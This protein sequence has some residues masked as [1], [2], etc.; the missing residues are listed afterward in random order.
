MVC[1]QQIP[2]ICIPP[3]LFFMPIENIFIK[4][5]FLRV[6]PKTKVGF[7]VSKDQVIL[8]SQ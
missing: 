4:F 5:L 3:Y 1:S 8:T 6:E 7:N 2:Q